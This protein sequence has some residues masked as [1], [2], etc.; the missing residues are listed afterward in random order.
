MLKIV[1]SI[2]DPKRNLIGFM[3][4]GKEKEFGGMSSNKVVQPISIKELI[5]R[6]FSNLATCL[7]IYKTAYYNF[8]HKNHSIFLL[9]QK[10]K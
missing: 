4:E 9:S 2:V 8:R 1:K 10:K 7:Y 5:N 3:L 6:K